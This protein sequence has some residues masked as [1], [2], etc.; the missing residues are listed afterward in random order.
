MFTVYPYM[1]SSRYSAT[2]ENWSAA[3]C[4]QHQTLCGRC[5]G[6]F[7][8]SCT[9]PP[10]SWRTRSHVVWC[11]QGPLQGAL[12]WSHMIWGTPPPWIC[13]R[14]SHSLEHHCLQQQPPPSWTLPCTPEKPQRM[15][16]EISFLSL[17]LRGFG[18]DFQTKEERKVRPAIWWL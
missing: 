9:P 6:R 8:S 14:M 10:T 5:S 13:I 18:L 1:S 12:H 11:V 17:G 15:E 3:W 16:I 2:T 7:S 4:G